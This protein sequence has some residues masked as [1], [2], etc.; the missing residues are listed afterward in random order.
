MDTAKYIANCSPRFASC[1]M[2]FTVIDCL[3]ERIKCVQ[4]YCTIKCPCHDIYGEYKEKLHGESAVSL[5]M[6]SFILK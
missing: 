5:G 6:I 1:V 2:L 4:L 3:A